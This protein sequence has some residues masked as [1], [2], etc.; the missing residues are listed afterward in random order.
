[1]PA[2]TAVVRFAL[3]VTLKVT[4]LLAAAGIARLLLR[5]MSAAGRHALTTLALAGAALLPLL[6]PLVPRLRVPLLAY[7][8]PKPGIE[9]PA[10]AVAREQVAKWKRE[11]SRGASRFAAS[12]TVKRSEPAVSGGAAIPSRSFE[13][14]PASLRRP[15]TWPQAAFL[16]WALGA[17]YAL[18]RLA[19]GTMRVRHIARHARPVFDL[20]WILAKDELSQRLGLTGPVRLLKSDGVAVAMTYGAAPPLLLLA[21]DADRW[22]PERRRL[23][24]LHELAHV[25]RR[26]WISLLLAEVVRAIYWFHPLVWGAV[27]LARKDCEKACDDLVLAFGTKPSVY[28]A[29]LLGI[30]RSLPRRPRLLPAVPMARPSQFESRM[31]AILDGRRPRRGLSAVEASLI[32]AGMLAAVVATGAVQPWFD[33]AEQRTTFL[34]RAAFRLPGLR[35][36]L[37]ISMNDLAAPSKPKTLKKPCEHKTGA[38]PAID[39]NRKPLAGSR[40]AV[41]G[42][43]EEG[44]PGGVSRGTAGGVVDGAL[45]GIPGGVAPGV[46]GGVLGSVEGGVSGGIEGFEKASQSETKKPAPPTVVG[47]GRGWYTRG[48]QLHNE[49]RYD[50]AIEAFQRSIAAGHREGA[51]S[52]NIACGY[53]RE[54]K[55]NEALDWLAR[56]RDAG[57]DVAGYIEKD[58][59][60]ESL[61]GL[62]GFEAMRGSSERKS[63]R[64]PNAAAE[65]ALESGRLA[66]EPDAS[67]EELYQAAKKLYSAKSYDL[68]ARAY[69][70][71]ADAG[72][73]IGTSRYNEAC[74]RALAGE[75]P[76]ALDLLEKS[77]LA[78]FDDPSLMRRDSDLASL[79]SEKRFDELVRMAEDLSLPGFGSKNEKFMILPWHERAR[80][81]A[82]FAERH[83]EIGRAWF[84]LGFAKIQTHEPKQA[85]HHVQPRLHLRATWRTGPL[86]PVALPRPRRGVRRQRHAEARFGPEQPA[87]GSAFPP[88]R[89]TGRAQDL[90]DRLLGQ[91]LLAARLA[92]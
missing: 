25:K 86:F 37:P 83:P 81:F 13:Q 32:G 20:D 31:R 64:R 1:M 56:A 54:G 50:E 65:A 27:G 73:R 63:S 3:D 55:A 4:I 51:A 49:G 61:Y 70:Q 68:A 58:D 87:R 91:P 22:T 6:S 19:T 84:N 41:R 59:D 12:R 28:A 77:I 80:H 76:L 60:L 40:T 36:L 10:P 44:V 53:A 48:M 5:R 35:S 2:D 24:L 33:C 21:A 71:S 7:P 52:Y 72:Y 62:A 47:G 74:S 43:V 30:V 46:K 16:V 89:G 14:P 75:R 82:A 69:H 45:G 9:R 57:F 79:H 38:S 42:G 15:M 66:G 18:A 34:R 26:D 17:A 39:R 29:H 67:G 78:G 88:S 90:V 8:F 11:D 92:D 23:V 85:H